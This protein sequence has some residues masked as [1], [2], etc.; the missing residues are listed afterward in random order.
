M[1][2][3]IL[4]YFHAKKTQTRIPFNKNRDI[5]SN[6]IFE[7]GGFRNHQKL[8]V[9]LSTT[10]T[11]MGSAD[12]MYGSVKSPYFGLLDAIVMSPTTL[13]YLFTDY[14]RLERK[15]ITK[16]ANAGNEKDA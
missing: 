12:I 4:G 5:I 1:R 2:P 10:G 13:S 9:W 6:H 3:Q 7:V 8:F 15:Q 11:I 14:P 16:Q